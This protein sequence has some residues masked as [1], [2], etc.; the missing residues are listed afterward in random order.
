[1]LWAALKRHR[2]RSFLTLL[3]VLTALAHVTGLVN[4]RVVDQLDRALY[5]LRLRLTLPGTLD[6]R[7]V[8]IDIDESSLSQLGQWPWGRQQLATLV[9]ELTQRQQVAA[10]GID[11]VFAEPDRSSGLARLRQAAQI[12]LKDNA[13]FVRWL[14]QSEATLDHDGQFARAL[15]QGSVALGFYLTS[16]RDGSRSGSLPTPLVTLEQS[17]AGLLAWDGYGANIAP[18]AQ[19]AS[20]A[21]FFN[22][23]TDADGLVRN[24]PMIAFLDGAIYESLALATVRSGVRGGVVSLMRPVLASGSAFGAVQLVSPQQKWHIPIDARGTALVPYRGQGGPAGGSFRYIPAAD[25]LLGKLPAASLQGK[26]ALLGFT[27]PG[28]M[29]MRV[30]PV[31]RAYPGVEVHANMIS[32]M[33]DG[34]IPSRPEWAPALELVSLIALGVVL[35]LNF[36]VL[37]VGKLVTLAG[38]LLGLIVIAT[39]VAWLQRGWV[40]PMAMTLALTALS[41]TGNLVLGYFFESRSRRE[42]VQ[43]FASYVPPELVRQMVLQPE[44]YSMQAQTQTLTVMFCDI[45]GFTALSESMAPLELQTLLNT[46]L[47]R[48]SQ[49]IRAHGG[50]IDKYVGDCVMAFWGAPIATDAHA[51]MA[52]KA[53]AAMIEAMDALNRERA[54]DGLPDIGVGIGLNTGL[55]SVGNMGSDVRRAYTV[56]GDAVNLAARLEALTRF[57]NVNIIVSEFTQ[58]LPD[59]LPAGLRWQELDRVR[60]RGRQQAVRIFTVRSPAPGQSLAALDDELARWDDALACWRRGEFALAHNLTQQ[61]QLENANFYLY[62]LQ[63]ERIALLVNEPPPSGWSGTV[64]F[65]SK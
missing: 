55:M 2:Y 11:A 53:A 39:T 34:R 9:I 21:G 56:I 60:V 27:A 58:A 25:V 20:H 49:A 19:A 15:A 24:V 35:I 6:E 32:G 30:T 62:R 63:S 1:M 5:D 48:L 44:R 38:V 22:A 8:I 23:I 40:L 43:Q 4:L 7:V 13:A 37:R 51:Q 10:L 17:P 42:L 47:S 45:R 61:L 57:Y 50:T 64:V 18:L 36:P 29:D 41:L 52:L 14:R 12:E 3:L 26:F 59:T 54:Q 33:L 31:G 28:L 65:D 46:V 16:D